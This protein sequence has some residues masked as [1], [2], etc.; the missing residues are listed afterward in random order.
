MPAAD[1]LSF[2]RLLLVPLIW[3]VALQGQ[4]R[5]VG[6]GLIAAGVTDA[7]DGY[8]A[9]RLG[10][11]STRGARLDAIADIVLLVSAAAWLQ[12]LHPEIARDNGALLA[13]TAALYACGVAAAVIAFRRV[14]DPSQLT[15]KI[16][17]GALYTFAVIT[18]LTGGYEP[19]L[20]RLALLALI[21]SSVES[22]VTAIRTIQ[23]RGIASSNR[24]QAPQPSKDVASSPS[25]ITSIASSATPTANDTGP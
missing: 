19:L 23:A 5:L 16:A 1:Y 13:T 7:L 18:L 8:L 22:I 24:S 25:P 17:G 3:L 4:S 11:V 10:Q 14:V 6:V 9:R 20:L 12:L 15:S 21:V 2:L